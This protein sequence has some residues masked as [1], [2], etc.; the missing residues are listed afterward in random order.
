MQD[1]A[2]ASRRQ[3]LRH[4]FRNR[5]AVFVM[6]GILQQPGRTEKTGAEKDGD[7]WTRSLPSAIDGT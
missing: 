5:V 1:E 6:A 7:G 3:A 4:Q 2:R